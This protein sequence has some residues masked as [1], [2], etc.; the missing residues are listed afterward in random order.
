MTTDQTATVPALSIKIGGATMSDTLAEALTEI[1]VENDLQVPDAATLRFHL[2][3]TDGDVTDLPD[4]V[5]KDYLQQG[6]VLEISHAVKNKEKRIF[7]GEVVSVSLEFSM[8]EPG[9]PMYATVQAFDRSHR[10]AC[11]IEIALR[12]QA[13]HLCRLTADERAARR[14]ARPRDTL[15]HLRGSLHV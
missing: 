11:K 7:S 5:M 14:L 10:E 6:A 13:R 1:E 15:D 8:H 3:A 9:S 2:N 12:I 4:K